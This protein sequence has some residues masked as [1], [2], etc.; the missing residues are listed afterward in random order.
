MQR[1]WA[2][3]LTGLLLIAA[4]AISGL[5]PAAEAAHASEVRALEFSVV[6]P[7]GNTVELHF[8][9]RADTSE[10][11]F[12]AATA[13]AR[14]LIPGAEFDA[15]DRA[16]AAYAFWPW[17]WAAELLPVP[18]AYNPAGAPAGITEDAITAGIAPWNAVESS[19]FRIGYEGV[20][21]AVPGL[22]ADVLDGQNVIGW[23]NM[24]CF[25]GCVLGITTK[26]SAAY[27]VDIVLN[28]NA[29]AGLGDGS[30]FSIDT[31]YVVLHELGHFA[32]LE[33]SC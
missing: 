10:A 6:T 22:H 8:S 16:S 24:N 28:S 33:H 9:V 30:G 5:R 1:W 18:V 25:V 13:A 17:Q 11:A 4:G 14:Q 7:A 15:G 20:T 19:A 12:E 26:S 2:P 21:T 29:A 23:A 3:G 32:G 27:E 31:T